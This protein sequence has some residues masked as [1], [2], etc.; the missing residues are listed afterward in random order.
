MLLKEDLLAFDFEGLN[1]NVH[2]FIRDMYWDFC[3]A[4][5]DDVF[6]FFEIACVKETYQLYCIAKVL[7]EKQVSKVIGPDFIV[8]GFV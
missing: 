5:W 3:K 8:V 4:V 2:P 1:F 7:T 6:S